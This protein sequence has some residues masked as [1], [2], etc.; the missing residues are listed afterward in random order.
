MNSVSDLNILSRRQFITGSAGLAA[1]L[2]VGAPCTGVASFM[3]Y[4][5]FSFYH[6]HTGETLS[7]DFNIKK[8]QVYDT[9]K[10]YHF[11]RD[12]RTG[13]THPIDR[14]L[15]EILYQLQQQTGSSGTFEVIS[16]YRSPHTNA[17]L[18][19]AGRGVATKS[20]HMKGMAMD[21]RLSDVDTRELKTIACSL[22]Q[23]GV[24]YYHK[25]DFIHIDTGRVRTW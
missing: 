17:R 16:G 12:F 23:G 6:T 21:I 18:Q 11:L 9:R 10:L 14:R 5:S 19:K 25:S 4:H 3:Q 8:Q 1:G 13:E 20:L 15:L 22:R 24:G 2:I 7:L